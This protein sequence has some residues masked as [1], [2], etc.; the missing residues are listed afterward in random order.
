[1]LSGEATQHRDAI[2]VEMGCDRMLYDGRYKLM[3]GDPSA[4]TRPL[5][6]LHLDKP[7]NIPPSPARLFDMEA[8]PSEENDLASGPSHRSRLESMSDALRPCMGEGVETLPF[9]DRGEYRP[10]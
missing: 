8:D 5:G 3:L 10:L 1:M 2:Y 6:R 9:L 4:D 7:V